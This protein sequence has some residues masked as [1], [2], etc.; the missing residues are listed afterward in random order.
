MA[1][2]QDIMSNAAGADLIS[3]Y[4]EQINQ[5]NTD[6]ATY[7]K[8]AAD[9]SVAYSNWMETAY[10]D[11]KYADK[12]YRRSKYRK[13]YSTFLSM[14]K[15]TDM[16]CVGAGESGRGSR[17]DDRYKKAIGY[18][19]ESL[20]RTAAANEFK[21]QLQATKD[22][23]VAAEAAATAALA[24]GKSQEAADALAQAEI[25][26]IKAETAELMANTEATINTVRTETETNPNTKY[27]IMGVIG[28]VALG[29]FILYKRAK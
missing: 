15:H 2:L 8:A 28:L 3:V 20:A 4:N 26:K 19:K 18:Y 5:L 11:W 7:E 25:D 24:A 27:I 6:I 17:F 23:L 21:K 9:Y 22:S 16:R 1:T 12:S 10:D 14:C 13:S 29:G